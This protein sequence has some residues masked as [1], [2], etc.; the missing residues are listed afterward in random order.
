MVSYG[1][2]A[3]SH[4]DWS[5]NPGSERI[6]NDNSQ[7]NVDELFSLLKF[8]HI[9]PW[10]EYNKFNLD[11]AQPIKRGIGA[12]IAMKRLQVGSDVSCLPSTQSHTVIDYPQANY[13][14][15]SKG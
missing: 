4:C 9:R 7:N 5:L 15:A 3:V 14:E 8:L 2:S 13:V 6:E 12:G 1:N 10:N 11:V